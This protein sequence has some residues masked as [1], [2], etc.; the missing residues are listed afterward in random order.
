MIYEEES[1][2]NKVH[3]GNGVFKSHRDKGGNRK[4]NGENFIG[5]RAG[6]VT[7]PDRETDKNVAEHATG[8]GFGKTERGFSNRDFK[9][10]STH[11]ALIMEPMP[12]QK[13]E[14]DDGNCPD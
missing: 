6:T 3:I 11:G 9:R 4:N 12:A 7:E 10:D 2:G 14:H 1:R 8:E 5:Y 13:N